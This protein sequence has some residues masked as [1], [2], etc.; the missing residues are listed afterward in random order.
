MHSEKYRLFN[1]S[2]LT[3][4]SVTHG[5][6]FIFVLHTTSVGHIISF[7]YNTLHN[8]TFLEWESLVSIVSI[9]DIDVEY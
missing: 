4:Q 6:E 1:I 7:Y 8:C 3:V 9:S 2:V 5:T